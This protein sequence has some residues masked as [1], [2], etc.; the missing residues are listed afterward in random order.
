MEARRPSAARPAR[1]PPRALNRA[2]RRNVNLF[3]RSGPVEGSKG[4]YIFLGRF[5]VKNFVRTRGIEHLVLGRA[6]S[7]RLSPLTADN[8]QLLS[9]TASSFVERALSSSDASSVASALAAAR[10]LAALQARRAQN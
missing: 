1:R 7:H 4:R 2:R 8:L 3:L 10:T 6:D 5:A 9:E